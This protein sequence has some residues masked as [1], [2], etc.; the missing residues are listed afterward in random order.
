M[1]SF[2]R[3]LS[4]FASYL[5]RERVKLN[6]SNACYTSERIILETASSSS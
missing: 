6:F 4:E 2:T 1:A 3:E 5:Y